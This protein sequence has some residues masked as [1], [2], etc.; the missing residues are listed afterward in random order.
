MVDAPGDVE[1]IVL[2]E[3]DSPD[4]LT[5]IRFHP[6][7][8]SILKLLPWAADQSEEMSFTAIYPYSKKCVQAQNIVEDQKLPARLL[9]DK[10]CK[11]EL[12]LTSV[13]DSDCNRI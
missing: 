5:G 2:P 9:Q 7:D 10:D 3:S 8:P 1:F 4:A 6:E 13:D 11:F 12:V